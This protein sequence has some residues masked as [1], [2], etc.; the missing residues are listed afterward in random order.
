MSLFFPFLSFLL[1]SL[2]SYLFSFATMY[3]FT[4]GVASAGRGR[5]L[6][7][8]L[9]GPVL[10]ACD[11]TG[12]M[13][14][15]ENSNPANRRFYASLGFERVDLFHPMADSPPLEPMQRLPR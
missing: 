13:A 3:L 6:G 15:L 8:R 9:I 12:T 4:V 2:S 5:G 7:R 10:D 1:T 11:R 14:Y